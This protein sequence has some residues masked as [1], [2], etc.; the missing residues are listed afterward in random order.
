MATKTIKKTET[1]IWLPPRSV[2]ER[3]FASETSLVALIHD[4]EGQ[5]YT[6]LSIDALP[7]VKQA[8]LIFDARDVTLIQIKLPPLAGAKLRQALPNAIEDRLLQDP[9]SCLI[10]LG[11]VINDEGARLVGVI[12]RAWLDFVVGAFERRGIRVLRATPGQLTSTFEPETASIICVHDGLA[13][14]TAQDDGLGWSAGSEAE[15]RIDTLNSAL[16]TVLVPPMEIDPAAAAQ[17]VDDEVGLLELL[18]PKG[19]A[20]TKIV[21]MIE[22]DSWLEVVT[23]VARRLNLPVQMASLPL[24]EKS[25]LNLLDGRAGSDV[26]R[27]FADINWR[28]LRVPAALVGASLAVFLLGLNLHWGKLATEKSELRA[29]M[30]NTFRETFPNAR[31]VVDPL[32]QMEREVARMRASAGQTG[33]E[34]FMPLMVRFSQALGPQAND[35]LTSLEYRDGRLLVSFQPSLVGARSVREKLQQACK[36]LGLDLKFEAGRSAVA[37]VGLL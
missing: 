17:I 11:P 32:L 36:Q 5:R 28:A 9:Q 3:A 22:D 13:I 12:D 6:R 31:V 1:V 27:R 7:A 18:K 30:V 8:T 16:A 20:A 25:S 26:G 23:E 14:R 24:P 37:Y 19:L 33:S 2:G 10:A 34:D 4:A 35:A 21:A 29:D 15:H